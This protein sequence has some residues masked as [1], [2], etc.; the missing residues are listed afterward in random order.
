MKRVQIYIGMVLLGGT[1]L[2]FIILSGCKKEITAE[3]STVLSLQKNIVDYAAKHSIEARELAKK[4]ISLWK[5]NTLD[6]HPV[7]IEAALITFSGIEGTNLGL[8]FYDEDK[9]VLGLQ[10][11]E[12]SQ[13]NEKA[14]ILKED[15][16]FYYY[17]NIAFPVSFISMEIDLRKEDIMKN[18]KEWDTFL[19]EN[20]PMISDLETTWFPPI[21]ISIPNEETEVFL[22]LYDRRGNESNQVKLL[23]KRRYGESKEDQEIKLIRRKAE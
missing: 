14:R 3:E 6:E 7:L 23:D 9:D 13:I 20:S 16:P 15:Y 22:S 19:K 1:F 12:H 5:N 21:Y 10:I 2:I 4:A 18:E 17:T 11:E 8:V